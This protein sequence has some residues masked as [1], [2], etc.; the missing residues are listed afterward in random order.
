VKS[1]LKYLFPVPKEDSKRVIT[2]ANQED[3]ISFRHHMYKKTRPKDIELTEVGPRFEMKLY[4]IRLGTME[5]TDADVEWRLKP[6]M[7]TARKRMALSST[8]LLD[9]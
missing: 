4:E 8:G 1:I 9:Q 2:F 5:Q 7:N 6:Y 3:Y